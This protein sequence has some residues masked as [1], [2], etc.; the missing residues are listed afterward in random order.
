MTTRRGFTLVELMVAMVMTVLVGGVVYR[1]LI[2][3][4]R[5]S[6]GQTARVGVQ[7]NV[8][9]GAIIA[10][11]ELREIGYDSVPVTAVAGIS[12]VLGQA[13]SSDLL[14]AQPGRLQYRAM[15]GFGV[16]CAVPT[17]A[18]LKL[19][20]ALYYGVRDPVANDSIA[21]FVEGSTSIGGD[22]SWVRAK[23]TGVGATTC[24]DGAAAL[25]VNLSWPNAGVGT[26]ATAA[27]VQGGPVRVFEAMEMRYYVSGGKSW[28]GMKSLNAGGGM[29]PVVGPIAD[30]TAGQ[31][32]MTLEYF[33]KN[34]VA[35]ATATDVRAIKLTLKGVTE[36]RVYKSG[37]QSSA[38]DTLSMSARVALRNALRP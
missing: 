14:L 5:V 25:S 15:R 17:A 9:A 23:I 27:E 7:D 20:R 37:G 1:L 31:R 19:R 34:D 6:R 33:D 2:N 16:T 26:A 30:S 24:T 21:I 3:N 18:Q 35:T 11:N 10:A 36:E 32:G 28:L 4:Q 22:D 29:E 12:A 8:R 38:V 13:P